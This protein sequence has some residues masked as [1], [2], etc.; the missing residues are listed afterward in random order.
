MK[1]TSASIAIATAVTVV[2]GLC[3]ALPRQSPAATD[4]FPGIYSI[5]DPVTGETKDVLKVVPLLNEYL[6]RARFGGDGPWTGPIYAKVM[7]SSDSYASPPLFQQDRMVS[8][9]ALGEI[10]YL[11]HT[12]GNKNSRVGPSDTGYISNIA[13]FGITTLFHRPLLADERGERGRDGSTSGA[14]ERQL[15]VS[16]LNYSPRM[17]QVGISSA[18]NPDNAVDTDPLHPYMSSAASC[19]LFLPAQAAAPLQ[20]KL[21]Y[22]WLPKGKPEVLALTLPAYGDAD[23]LL[24]LVQADGSMSVEFRAPGKDL[25]L[26]PEGVKSIN[27]KPYPLPPAAERK[28]RLA[29]ELVRRKRFLKDM[30]RLRDKGTGE[31]VEATYQL[32]YLI[33]EYE[34]TITYLETFSACTG[35]LAT[36]HKQAI[37]AVRAP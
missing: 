6:V 7:G 32:R 30:Y 17:I 1:A 11:Y 9:L 35:S 31:S 3:F 21:E 12:P 27:G 13:A 18:S 33:D 10:G 34:K 25:D 22:R 23:E 2:A 26:T 4:P 37:A 8:A 20:V 36:C 15:S 28:A 24:I 14:G 29:A 19:C 16:T 5:I